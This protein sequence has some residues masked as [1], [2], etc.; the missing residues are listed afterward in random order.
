MGAQNLKNIAEPMRAWRLSTDTN[1]AALL[2]RDRSIEIAKPLALPDKPS[3]AVLSFQNMSSDPE[4]GI[5]RGRH[6]RRHHHGAVAQPC[7]ACH[8]A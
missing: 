6:R 7:I 2:L 4:Q 8:R 3:I 5:L 1:S